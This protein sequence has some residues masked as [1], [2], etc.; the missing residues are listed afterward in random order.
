M[1]TITLLLLL[2]MAQVATSQSFVKQNFALNWLSVNDQGMS[3]LTYSGPGASAEMAFCKTWNRFF[4]ETGGTFGGGVLLTFPDD[5]QNVG[6]AAATNYLLGSKFLYEL[7]INFR[8]FSFYT[9]ADAFTELRLRLNSRLGNSTPS[10]EAAFAFGPALKSAYPVSYK[11]KLFILV[12]SVS[13]PIYTALV[14]PNYINLFNYTYPD[15]DMTSDLLANTTSGGPVKY[16][17]LKY[18]M[19]IE[20]EFSNRNRVAF[21]F[22]AT[23]YRYKSVNRVASLERKIGFISY[24]NIP[25]KK[26]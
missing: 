12:G 19:R 17:L 14:R 21:Y 8:K 4:I 15:F 5:L 10:Y 2:L 26:I 9:G 13:L 23:A 22:G 25:E 3:P 6:I 11:G 16:F 24:F 20:N 1:R 18:E 7:P